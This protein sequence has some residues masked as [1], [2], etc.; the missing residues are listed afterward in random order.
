M[1]AENQ[2]GPDAGA[3]LHARGIVGGQTGK[4][5]T[6]DYVGGENALGEHAKAGMDKA[7]EA[8][9]L[10]IPVVGKMISLLFSGNSAAAGLESEGV[11]DKMIMPT[12]GGVLPDSQGGLLARILAMIAKGRDPIN[13]TA[14]VTGGTTGDGGAGTGGGDMAG[15]GDFTAPPDFSVASAQFSSNATDMVDFGSGNFSATGNLPSP[16]PVDAPIMDAPS[17]GGAAIA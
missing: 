13:M 8:A 11:K 2:P 17:R 10:T 3:L 9:G 7:G 12:G 6:D 15:G 5:K 16:L 14:D 4:T 1:A